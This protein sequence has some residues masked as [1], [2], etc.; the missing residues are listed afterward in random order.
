MKVSIVTL[1]LLVS[2]AA[3]LKATTLIDTVKSG[4]TVIIRYFDKKG[5]LD[6]ENYTIDYTLLAYRNW[7][8]SKTDYGYY[9]HKNADHDTYL[10]RR[11]NLNGT[12]EAEVKFINDQMEGKALSYFPNGNVMC[13]CNYRSGEKDSIQTMYFENG[14][15]EAVSNY[16]NGKLEGLTT[17]YFS[18]GILWSEVLYYDNVPFTVLSNFNKSGQAVEKGD[19]KDGN[20]TRYEYDESGDLL[21][22]EYYIDGR[23]K[24]TEKIKKND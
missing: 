16:K 4:D 7:F 22:I 19:L 18:N 23:L 14:N 6:M 9:W 5:R 20:G 8:Y 10:M 3:N 12:I 13:I 1:V 17:F 21:F 15:L 2:F 24:K 11:F